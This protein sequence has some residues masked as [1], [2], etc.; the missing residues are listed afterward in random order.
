MNNDSN[1]QNM[2]W[3][4]VNECKRSN[5]LISGT[6]AQGKSLCA[7][8]ICDSLMKHGFQIYAIDSTGIWKKKASI[9]YYYTVSETTMRYILPKSSLIYDVSRLT[10]SYQREFLENILGEIWLRRLDNHNQWLIIAIE[11]AHLLMRHIRGRASENLLRICSV[12]R[13]INMRTLA[14]SP[15]FV[16]LDAE[17]RRLSQQR[18]HFKLPNESNT[19]RRFCSIYSKDWYRVAKALDIGF[20]IYYNNERMKVLKIPLFISKRKPIPYIQPQPKKKR[21]SILTRIFKRGNSYEFV[22]DT[23]EC[24]SDHSGLPCGSEY[25][26]D[27]GGF[28]IEDDS[29]E[30]GD[31]FI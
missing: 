1:M 6:N 19:K 29:E 2:L 23:E 15:S 24:V 17:F 4:D 10:A 12:G 31:E 11:E 5:I 26:K 21:R 7:M 3:L 20:C 8:A 30:V 14:I 9:P 16:G 18:Y 27:E 25:E 28:I 22:E 13:N